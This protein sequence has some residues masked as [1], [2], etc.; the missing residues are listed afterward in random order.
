MSTLDLYPVHFGTVALVRSILAG[1]AHLIFEMF[2]N[3]CGR[4]KFHSSQAQLGT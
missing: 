3:W 4:E 1:L 2:I